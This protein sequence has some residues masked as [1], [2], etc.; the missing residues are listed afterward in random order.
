MNSDADSSNTINNALEKSEL[1]TTI[2]R[3]IERI[4]RATQSNGVT[5]W[6]MMTAIGVLVW[7]ALDF[8]DSSSFRPTAQW[9]VLF[10]LCALLIKRS[11]S[12]FRD[13]GVANRQQYFRYP[14]QSPAR[15]FFV[16]VFSLNFLLLAVVSER[17][18]AGNGWWRW[19]LVIFFAFHFFV[20]LMVFVF[21]KFPM[22]EG[23]TL[24]KVASTG[25]FVLSLAMNGM[26]C[27]SLVVI[28][29]IIHAEM[30]I[31]VTDSFRLGLLLAVSCWLVMILI[32]GLSTG[33][34]R[35]QMRRLELEV[36]LDKVEPADGRERFQTLMLGLT[37]QSV[38]K[39]WIEDVVL[40]L[41]D[42]QSSL[43]EVGALLDVV[44]KA[45]SD[46]DSVIPIAARKAMIASAATLMQ[47]AIERARVATRA[48]K[49]FR[50][51]T[52]MLQSGVEA[53]VRI[54]IQAEDARIQAAVKQVNDAL[55]LVSG[56][57]AGIQ[58]KA[59]SA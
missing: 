32:G 53:A 48:M 14:L 36:S 3:E 24:N 21:S 23:E 1:V 38:L 26:H 9:F 18:T 50:R 13:N 33:E 44:E 20:S 54:D 7:R 47:S 12:V 41:D 59:A 11:V 40:P 35:D 27:V 4:D 17:V 46:E 34:R 42:V 57:I 2:G 28:A 43:A 49:Q 51:K 29:A 39:P 52:L 15:R 6:V 25:E 31:E 8:A 56:R 10:W 19:L 55:S 16:I 45:I 37:T 30:K 5:Q 22:P 58:Q